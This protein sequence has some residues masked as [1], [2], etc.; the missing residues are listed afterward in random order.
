MTT[1]IQDRQFINAVIG[2]SL[3]EEAIQWIRDNMEPEDVFSQEQLEDWAGGCGFAK[4]S[5]GS[6]L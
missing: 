3:L 2:K 1:T 5:D 6:I 4:I